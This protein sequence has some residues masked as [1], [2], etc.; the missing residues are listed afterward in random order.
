MRRLAIITTAA[1]AVLLAPASASAQQ[2][3]PGMRYCF[4]T[5]G[6]WNVFAKKG[7]TSCRYARAHV[8]PI[9]R[10][11]NREP[12]NRFERGERF[13]VWVKSPVTGVTYLARCRY[14][15]GWLH[16]ITCR[17]GADAKVRFEQP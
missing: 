6:S 17:S 12:D 2:E 4:T 13:R 11:Q 8:R 5:A 7:T 10:R 3:P 16:A 14:S 1:L 15:T 9:R